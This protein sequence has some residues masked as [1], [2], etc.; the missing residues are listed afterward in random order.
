L[1]TLK[2]RTMWYCAK[3]QGQSIETERFS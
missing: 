2:K 1:I 3:Q